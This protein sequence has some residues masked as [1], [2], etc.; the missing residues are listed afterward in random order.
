M[1]KRP[2]SD[3]SHSEIIRR[4]RLGDLRKL[5]RDRYG[6]MLPDDDAGRED[7]RELLLPISVGPHAS[8]KM[9]N[10]IE[11]WAPWMRPEEATQ[12]I[13]DINRSPIW[14]RKPTADQLGERQALMNRQRERLKL[15]TIA[16]CNMNQEQALEWR[17]AKD[18]ARKRRRRQL[19]GSVSRV[20][21]LAKHAI[22]NTKPWEAEGIKRRAWYYRRS[23]SNCTSP[24]ELKLTA[25]RTHLCNQNKHRRARTKRLPKQGGRASKPNI[26]TKAEKPKNTRKM[27]VWRSD[28]RELCGRTCAMS[29]VA[30]TGDGQS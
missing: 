7:L 13:D 26:S 18:R 1:S 9:P 28:A 22:S 11:V 10:A 21:Y 25:V 2:P 3:G 16:A 5:L 27:Y 24:S 20:E 8:L 6:P 4:L 15:W 19:L 17:K 29:M 14:Q 12:L 23:K 30:T